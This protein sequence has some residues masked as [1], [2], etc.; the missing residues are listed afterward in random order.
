MSCFVA[1]YRKIDHIKIFLQF[2]NFSLL[3]LQLFLS[4][5]GRSVVKQT[6]TTVIF[7]SPMDGQGYWVLSRWGRTNLKPYQRWHGVK[8]SW[9]KSIQ[10]NFRDGSRI[11]DQFPWQESCQL[12]LRE[13]HGVINWS[14]L[15]RITKEKILFIFGKWD[16]DKGNELIY[17]GIR[18]FCFRLIRWSI[19][20]PGQL[21]LYIPHE[22]FIIWEYMRKRE[23]A[24]WF[25]SLKKNSVL[26]KSVRIFM[27]IFPFPA[28][29]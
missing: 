7:E 22:F 9:I 23:G 17:I 21:P 25:W 14:L 20:G 27:G 16:A 3:H 15:L 10:Q 2:I 26:I 4:G 8:D 1:L 18:G 24:Y 6:P 13:Q 28:N 11:I 19:T 5:R 12:P 29:N